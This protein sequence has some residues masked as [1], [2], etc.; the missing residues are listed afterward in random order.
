MF[1]SFVLTLAPAD[2][3]GVSYDELIIMECTIKVRIT[4]YIISAAPNVEFKPH[5]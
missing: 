5:V 1:A 3:Y 2:T 4:S